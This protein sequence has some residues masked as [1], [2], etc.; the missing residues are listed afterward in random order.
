MDKHYRFKREWYD[1]IKSLPGREFISVI[2]EI[3]KY[4]FTSDEH[5]RII[6]KD[7]SAIWAIINKYLHYGKK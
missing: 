5:L 1:A 2:N 3:S 4:A 6:K 7:D